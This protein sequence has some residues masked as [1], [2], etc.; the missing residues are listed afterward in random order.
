MPGFA[1]VPVVGFVVVVLVPGLADCFG[2]VAAVVAVALA[3][4]RPYCPGSRLVEGFVAVLGVEVYG[5]PGAG[6][7]WWSGHWGR[8]GAHF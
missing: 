1:P 6:F 3:A 5:S 4:A 7:V 8:V 2:F